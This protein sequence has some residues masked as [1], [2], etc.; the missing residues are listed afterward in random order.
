M[1]QGERITA[2]ETEVTSLKNV[3][4]EMNSKLDELLVLKAQGQGAF[5][6]ATTIFGTSVALFISYVVSWFK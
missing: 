6:L 2:L 1:T 5:W 3:V 4:K